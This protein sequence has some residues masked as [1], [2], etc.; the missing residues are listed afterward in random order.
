MI[1]E[2]LELLPHNPGCYLMKDNKGIV[3]YVGKA[4]DLKKRVTS[5]FNRVHTGKTKVLVDHIDTF[6]YIITKT[7]TEALILELN[8][9]K[10]YNP[11]YNILLRD[12]KSYPYI[13]LTNEEYPRILIVRDHL[14]RKK[15]S[16]LFGPYPNTYAARKIVNLLN[17]IYPLRKCVKLPSQ[18][19]L[20]YHLKQCLGYCVYQIDKDIIKDMVNDI[21]KFL[22]G[23][24]EFLIK[25]I[26]NKMHEA[27]SKL[28]YEKALDLKRLLDDIEIISK[29]QLM[30]LNNIIDIDIFGYA[31]DGD[32]IAVQV[33][34]I[35]N[36][37]IVERASSLYPLVDTEDEVLTYYI[38]SFYEGNNIKPKEIFV[39]SNIDKELLSELL[40]IKVITPIKGKKKEILDLAFHNAQV[41]LNE[42]KEL[43]NRD[44][45]RNYK[46]SLE[47]GNI[48]NIDNLS[49]VEI[50]DN[51]HLFGTSSVSGMVVFIDGKPNKNEYRKYKVI[52][53]HKD[54]YNLMKEVIYRRY[55]RVIKENLPKP[56]LIIVDGGKVQI[57]AA[58]E[59]L[60]MLNLNI[61]VCGLKKN[62]K[63]RT[64]ALLYENNIIEIDP[65]TN[66][67]HLLER[68]QNEIHR[69][70]INYH[71]QIRSKGSLES[72]LDNIPG[73]GLK[74]KQ[75]L[76][77]K[78]GS[79]SKIKDASEEELLKIL[80]LKV[81]IELKNIISPKEGNDE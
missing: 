40:N 36:G 72:V 1:N 19:C 6:E 21:V 39:P 28:N 22:K 56:D 49:R 58:L 78:F 2:K 45:E 60:I 57:N 27:S 29:K 30:E 55:H 69:Y 71:K 37:K 73:I 26:E 81:V 18:V 31:T 64:E 75:N 24:D 3:I 79:L 11:K 8:L 63:H 52:S 38:G 44:E 14:K 41:A 54:D 65:H 33:F 50:F 48:L 61:P 53:E 7:E 74:R 67:F 10:K 76:L 34:H 4:K 66:V 12:D 51:S 68:M 32:V 47:L 80:P 15:K 43:L 9:I 46:S 25:N 35:R 62:E 17:Q 23:N 5:Y 16:Y 42:K 20:Y 59:V 70:T 77:K 13:E